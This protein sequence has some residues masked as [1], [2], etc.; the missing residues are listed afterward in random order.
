MASFCLGEFVKTEGVQLVCY[1]FLLHHKTDVEVPI[2]QFLFVRVRHEA[3][4]HI[5]VFHRRVAADRLKAAVVIRK[6]ESVRRHHHTG[7][8]ASEEHHAVLHGIIA[9]IECTV[10]Q[11]VVLL[12]HR[13]IDCLW[14]VIQRPHT[15]I[16]LYW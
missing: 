4:E 13:F 5:F 7:A 10:W 15:L 6:H 3:V 9:L 8:V 12:L 11:F 14:Q 2:G 16:G 1:I